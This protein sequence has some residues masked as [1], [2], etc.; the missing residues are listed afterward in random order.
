MEDEKQ[1]LKRALDAA[2]K[3]RKE[4]IGWCEKML[5]QARSAYTNSVEKLKKGGGED[6]RD[7]GRNDGD[8]NST[9]AGKGGESN[10][11][12]SMKLPHPP[13]AAE[14]KSDDKKVT[15]SSRTDIR[16]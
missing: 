13:M 10:R 16:T 12:P 5:K 11:Q 6:Y 14:G 9:D 15:F 2:F 1:G 8:E 7:D 4:Q 3:A